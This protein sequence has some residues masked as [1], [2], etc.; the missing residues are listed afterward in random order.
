LLITRSLL[1]ARE[2]DTDEDENQYEVASQ[3]SADD[4]LQDWELLGARLP[5]DDGARDENPD[6]IGN[7]DFDRM[8]DRSVHVDRYPEITANYWDELRDTHSDQL[9]P[10]IVG[11]ADL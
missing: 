4:V 3:Q 8:Y 2:D 9:L 7:R 10:L 6:D 5:N 1:D 11:S